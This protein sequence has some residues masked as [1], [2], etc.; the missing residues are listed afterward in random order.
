M[1]LA[2][3]LIGVALITVAY[4]N[5]YHAL[6]SQLQ[7]DAPGFAKWAI[8]IVIIGALQYVPN[9]NAAAKGL[10]ALV[11]LGIV[12]A[13][14]GAFQQFQTAIAQAPAAVQG[15]SQPALTGSP[16]ISVGNSGGGSSAGNA[17]S[18]A[19]SVLNAIPIIGGLF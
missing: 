4:R 14:H 18:A 11:I 15:G 1:P 7:S 10:L 12:L 19:G 8:A 16:T 9:F 17:A 5:T 3:L 6:F 2:F 13:N